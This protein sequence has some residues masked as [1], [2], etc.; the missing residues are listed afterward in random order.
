MT[1]KGREYREKFQEFRPGFDL[2]EE[3][4]TGCCRAAGELW[5]KGICTGTSGWRWGGSGW[6]DCGSVSQAP[7]PYAPGDL[8]GSVLRR[9]G[10]DRY[11]R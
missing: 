9:R 7:K 8:A 10:L 6:M 3:R 11:V 2:C 1:A 5:G 4:R